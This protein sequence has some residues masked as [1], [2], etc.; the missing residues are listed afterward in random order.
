MTPF[1][2]LQDPFHADDESWGY[3]ELEVYWN[4]KFA[5]TGWDT[6]YGAQKKEDEFITT[7]AP[8]WTDHLSGWIVLA[9]PFLLFSASS[10]MILN[11]WEGLV[12]ADDKVPPFPAASDLN[13]LFFTYLYVVGYA[14]F[15][16]CYCKIVDVLYPS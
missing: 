12:I 11:I 8:L 2:L 6:W 9:V 14:I 13:K 3:L 5:M 16:F 7:V 4:L 15:V 10:L 1:L